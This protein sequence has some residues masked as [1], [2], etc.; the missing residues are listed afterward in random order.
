MILDEV[1]QKLVPVSGR[2]VLAFKELRVGDQSGR[3]HHVVGR[4]MAEGFVTSVRTASK[5]LDVLVGWVRLPATQKH[6]T[7]E[8]VG[9]R[10]TARDGL[11]RVR[12][13]TG[14]NVGGGV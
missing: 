5:V 9:H 6:P 4:Q 10:V 8:T 14:D 1:I 13:R 11:V 3:P 12:E 2:E 7:G